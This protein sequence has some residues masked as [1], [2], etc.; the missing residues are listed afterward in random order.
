MPVSVDLIT[1]MPQGFLKNKRQAIS[2][3]F[4]CLRPVEG[5]LPFKTL[6]VFIGKVQRKNM[7]DRNHLCITHTEGSAVRGGLG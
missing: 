1:N 5:L 3:I 6:Q 7:R 4:T 2:S